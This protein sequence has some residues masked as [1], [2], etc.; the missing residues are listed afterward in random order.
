MKAVKT[1]GE[2][3]IV[4]NTWSCVRRGPDGIVSPVATRRRRRTRRNRSKAHHRRCV[5]LMQ[6]GQ[7]SDDK[8]FAMELCSCCSDACNAIKNCG[9]KM[10]KQFQDIQL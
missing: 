3:S 9:I 10:S 6:L 5:Q 8:D 2:M 7:L 4:M 1:I